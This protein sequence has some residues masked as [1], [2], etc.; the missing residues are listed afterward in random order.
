MFTCEAIEKAKPS[1]IEALAEKLEPALARAVRDLIKDHVAS[2][3]LDD[4]E[5]ALKQGQ[6]WRIIDII[7]DVDPVKAAAVRE[8]LQNAVWAG[9]A[10]AVQSP[11]LREARFAFQ[12]L[13]PVLISWLESY[14]LNLIRDIQEG[15]RAAVRT[16]LVE[17]MRAGRG[18]ID[19]ARQIKQAVGLT[20]TQAKSVQNYRRE[21]EN[22]HKKRSAKRWGLGNERSRQSGLEVLRVDAKTGKP[23]D[24]IEVRRLRDQRYDATLKRAME[25]GVPLKPEQID[26][27]VD[28]YQERLVQNRARTIARSESIRALNVGVAEAW[29]QAIEERKVSGDLVRKRWI[30][31]RDERLCPRCSAIAKAQPKRGIPL[32]AKFDNPKGLAPVSQPPEHPSCR[33][34]LQIRLWEPEQ[35]A[36]QLHNAA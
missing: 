28:R 33:C 25:T 22:Y 5:E 12:R 8:Q 10:L 19:Q 18:S 27:M 35:L 7:G 29:R 14:S 6:T 26:K 21:L 34:V 1:D 23:V 17:G 24:G 4:L 3:N 11:A 16:A 9:G 13:N 30:I 2:V 32:H 31:S 36:E 15:T 20:A